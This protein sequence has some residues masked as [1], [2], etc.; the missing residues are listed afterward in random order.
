MKTI[1]YFFATACISYGVAMA[2]LLSG[3]TM[4]QFTSLLLAFGIWGLFL[5]HVNGIMKRKQ[6][7]RQR[8]QFMDHILRQRYRK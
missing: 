2:G 7:E 4:N 8:Q 5:W 3:G 1:I 6:Q